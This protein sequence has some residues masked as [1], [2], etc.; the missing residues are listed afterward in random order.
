MALPVNYFT[1]V[2]VFT[3]NVKKRGSL[4]FVPTKKSFDEN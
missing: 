1:V 3:K 2:Q 4:V